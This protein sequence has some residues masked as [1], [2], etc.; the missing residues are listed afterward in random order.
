MHHGARIPAVT[1]GSC[2]AAE[3]VVMRAEPAFWSVLIGTFKVKALQAA[4]E[5]ALTCTA[6]TRTRIPDTGH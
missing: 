1:R 5:Y 3:S 2:C 4:R 6:A